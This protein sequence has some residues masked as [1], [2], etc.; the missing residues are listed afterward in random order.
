MLPGLA[1]FSIA[2]GTLLKRN[3]N[4]MTNPFGGVYTTEIYKDVL[5]ANGRIVGA[6]QPQNVAL[7]GGQTPGNQIR[8]NLVSGHIVTGFVNNRDNAPLCIR[9]GG[10][11]LST[12]LES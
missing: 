3:I 9:G 8:Y 7:A 5:Y 10:N 6:S 1:F 2:S 12:F 11:V 4:L